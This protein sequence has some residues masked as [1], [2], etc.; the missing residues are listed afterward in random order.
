M[1]K[2]SVMNKKH[3]GQTIKTATTAVCVVFFM[4]YCVAVFMC[5]YGVR[6]SD[7]SRVG[8][9][10]GE[11][12]SFW[13]AVDVRDASGLSRGDFKRDYMNTGKPVVIRGD[14][15]A[16]ALTAALTLE[17]LL[18]MCGEMSPDLGNRLVRVL[19]QGIPP[20][21]RRD[22]DERLMHTD[23]VTLEHVIAE[24]RGR[25]KT[26]TMR[27]FFESSFFA[28]V[29]TAQDPRF[30]GAVKD[31][32]HPG[33]YVWPPSIH[34]WR[35]KQCEALAKH[36]HTSLSRHAISY[37]FALI[38]DDPRRFTKD[39]RGIYDTFMFAS[40]DK[41]RAY[42]PHIHG[43]PNHTVLLILQGRKRIVTWPADQAD[44]LYPVLKNQLGA[45]DIGEKNEIYM[46][47]GFNVDLEQQPDLRDVVGGLEG[48]AGPGDL[49]YIPCG[50]V[51]TLENAGDMIAIGW[52]PT[53]E[54]GTS[55]SRIAQCP[56]ANAFAY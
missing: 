3:K 4:C 48:E 54:R 8:P 2:P 43:K 19:R 49:L 41:C 17:T 30:P 56:N 7:Q 5:Y 29:Q 14:T 37:L 6:K 53:Q 55:E 52:L 35:V 47:D 12:K 32:S 24:M 39:P 26:R 11:Y 25:G 9:D 23:G 22:I 44:K 33:D 31:W 15:G 28:T 1:F 42:H 16:L 27:D 10:G 21:L 18:S 13:G 46:A 50:T 34:S 20:Q 45:N 38:E 40:G 36:V 51:H